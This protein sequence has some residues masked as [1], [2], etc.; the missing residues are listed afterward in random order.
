MTPSL[1]SPAFL[2]FRLRS[3]AL[4]RLPSI[5]QSALQYFSLNQPRNVRLQTRH[6]LRIFLSVVSNDSSC[7]LWFVAPMSTSYWYKI[8]SH[9]HRKKQWPFGLSLPCFF[10]ALVTVRAKAILVELGFRGAVG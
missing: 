8:W 1:R 7:R 2:L 9:L 3:R 6:V 5:R 10:P 4:R